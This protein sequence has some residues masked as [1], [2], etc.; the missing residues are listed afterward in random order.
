MDKIG[1]DRQADR[2]TDKP[3]QQFLCRVRKLQKKNFAESEKV[4]FF[5]QSQTKRILKKTLQSQKIYNKKTSLDG[6]K[7][8]LDSLP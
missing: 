8:Y 1:S 2:I 4:Q 7:P 3:P 6:V 5:L